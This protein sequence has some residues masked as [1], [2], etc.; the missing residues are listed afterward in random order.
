MFIQ[1]THMHLIYVMYLCV[2]F[3]NVDVDIQFVYYVYLSQCIHINMASRGCA[4]T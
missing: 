3:I 2:Y 1:Y 4:E